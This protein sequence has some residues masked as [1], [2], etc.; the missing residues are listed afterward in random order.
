MFSVSYKII[1][2]GDVIISVGANFEGFVLELFRSEV[3]TLDLRLPILESRG[4]RSLDSV[5]FMSNLMKNL[6]LAKR[7]TLRKICARLLIQNFV[8]TQSNRSNSEDH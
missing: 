4:S 6:G 5:R 8:T 3:L 1:G 7:E 2:L